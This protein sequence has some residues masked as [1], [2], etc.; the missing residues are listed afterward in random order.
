MAEI[1]EITVTEKYA[2]LAVKRVLAEEGYS[3]RQI[4]RLNYTRGI[5]LN[6]ETCRLTEEV[7]AGDVIRLSFTG[8]DSGKAL[9]A[10]EKPD[11]LYED[12]NIVVVCKPA[13]MPCHASKEHPDDDMGTLLMRV[14]GMDHVPSPVGRLDKD[15]SG[16]ILYAKN[17]KSA[18]ALSAQRDKGILHKEYLAAVSGIFEKKQDRMVFALGKDARN[19]RRKYDTDGQQCVTEYEVVQEYDGMSLLRVVILTGRTH[20]IR[21]GFAG[22]GHPL[23]GDRL[24]GGDCTHIYRPALHCA[25][26]VFRMPETGRETVLACDL[27]EDMQRILK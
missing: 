7:K 1:L 14:C 22:C 12:K 2:G 19:H 23:L 9:Q 26:L 5:Q 6:E 21:A 10:T 27:P 11:I 16:V 25:K 8:T 20:Q 17:R 18:A 13:G 15:V 4:S 24:Y 3:R